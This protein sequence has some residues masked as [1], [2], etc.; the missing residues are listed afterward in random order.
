MKVVRYKPQAT[1]TFHTESG[2]LVARATGDPKSSLNN[3]VI[4]IQ[5]TRSMGDDSPTFSVNLTRNKHWHKWIASN[6]MVVISMHR[7]P[8]TSRTVFVGL[9]DD[10]R[11]RIVMQGDSPQR[12]ITV[13]G[14]GVA[15][16]FIVPDIGVVP[17]ADVYSTSLGWLADKGVILS[18][19][20]ASTIIGAVWF[21]ICKQIVNY[22]W[23][24]GKSLFDSIDLDLTDKEGFVLL[25]DSNILNWQG[26]IQAFFKEV[27]E[28]PF[29]ELFWE[30]GKQGKPVMTVRPTPFNPRE[31]KNLHR[32]VISDDDVAMEEIGRSDT[33][34]YTLFSVGARSQFTVNDIY[35]TMGVRPYWNRKYADKYGIKRLQAHSAYLAVATASDIS[36]VDLMKSMQEDL[37]NWNIQNN[38]M[39]NGSFMV[40]GSNRYK[41]GNRLLYES[42][43]DNSTIEYYI[44]SVNHNFTN[45]GEWI[46]ELG[47][48]R[49][50]DPSKR[51]SYPFGSFKEYD[52]WELLKYDPDQALLNLQSTPDF[53]PEIGFPVSPPEEEQA[54]NVVNLAYD[55]M[56][57]GI[58]ISRKKVT[59]KLGADNPYGGVLDCSS[60]T[61]YVYKT[62]AGVVT[63]RSTGNQVTKGTKITR[64]QI[65]PGDL[66]F[67]KNTY[68]SGYVYGV[69][70]VGI[71]VG[72]DKFIHNIPRRNVVIDS[73]DGAYW[74]KHFLMFRRILTT[75]ADN[76]VGPG[77]N[78][79]ATAY[80]ANIINLGAPPGYVPTGKTASGTVPLEG[81][82]IAV[83]PKRIPLG[84][85]VRID[86]DYP[87]ISGEYIAEDTG[88]A[89]KGNRI[90]IYFNDMPP[91]DPHQARKR[92]LAFGKR[93][94]KVTVLRRGK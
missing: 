75:A 52:G 2:E 68:N 84:S 12:A 55:I 56:A 50:M 31:W 62:A 22:K 54:R 49:G 4:S 51:F 27:A 36:S 83:D 87:G 89:I 59:Y 40:K 17:E 41:I 94:V 8:E 92:M 42:K 33:E 91:Y 15:K 20:P 43:E 9:V 18:G 61:Q 45:F 70:H 44:T 48:T 81:R 46:T 93:N 6:D 23:S 32:H 3:D 26:S 73:L 67:F 13:T 30:I 34:T 71:C 28:E 5:T 69:S 90:D 25:D 79:V 14:R 66:V 10:C 38:S 39:F 47:V 80:G 85:K 37:F 74:K 16:A 86:S 7:P 88:G 60:F 63:G 19:S 77:E 72:G 65:M 35:H 24:N 11:K 57:N 76:N 64:D 53:S 1:V 21:N 82:T 58:G 78:Y 29:Y